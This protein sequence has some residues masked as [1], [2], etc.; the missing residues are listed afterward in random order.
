MLTF[1]VSAWFN[2]DADQNWDAAHPGAYIQHLKTVVPQINLE[3]GSFAPTG[4]RC[5]IFGVLTGPSFEQ[6][7]RSVASSLYQLAGLYDRVDVDRMDMQ[8]GYLT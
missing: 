1:V 4:G 7:D 3:R 6:V 5:G 8:S 2:A